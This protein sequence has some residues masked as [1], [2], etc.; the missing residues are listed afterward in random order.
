MTEPAEPALSIPTLLKPYDLVLPGMFCEECGRNK[1]DRLFHPYTPMRNLLSPAPAARGG[2]FPPR[3][4]PTGC[5][6]CDKVINAHRCAQRP[7]IDGLF[8]GDTWTCPH[9][10]LVWTARV[11]VV[12][13]EERE[14][15][16]ANAKEPPA[17]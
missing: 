17:G 15:S 14:W 11:E 2:H 3:S 12:V 8:D 13:S 7:D 4:L 16:V 9:C 5:S 10:R 1:L 6:A